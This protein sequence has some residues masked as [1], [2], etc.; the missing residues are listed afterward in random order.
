[1][2]PPGSRAKFFVAF[3]HETYVAQVGLTLAR[4]SGATQPRGSESYFF[5]GF[6]WGYPS[7]LARKVWQAYNPV[8]V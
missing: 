2:C 6:F 4:S 3:K 7:S 1:M 5:H 8:Y